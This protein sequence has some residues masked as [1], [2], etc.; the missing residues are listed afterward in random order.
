MA[1][2]VDVVLGAL[3]DPTRRAVFEDIL[4]HGPMTATALAG[5][6]SISRQAVTKHLERLAQ[7]G[8]AHAER[9]GRETLWSADP[10]PLA[11]ATDWMTTVGQAWDKRLERLADRF[12]K[13]T[14]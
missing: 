12:G 4:A 9:S 13:V 6:R 7:A 2:G 11:I 1:P 10:R 3:A 8:L 5:D 14:E